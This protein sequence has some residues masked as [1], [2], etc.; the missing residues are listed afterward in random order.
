MS[1]LEIV[2]ECVL[3]GALNQRNLT[4]YKLRSAGATY[5]AI[6][7]EF[8]VTK[9][10]ARQM[11]GRAHYR[12]GLFPKWGTLPLRYITILSSIGIE[13]QEQAKGAIIIGRLM[14]EICR[15]RNY[16]ATTFEELRKLLDRDC[17]TNRKEQP[18]K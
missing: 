1:D 12:L 16:K 2:E 17:G 6:G 15:A 10:R 3:S 9:E 4:A 18:V 13:N 8:H 5:A 14:P 7:R 11:V